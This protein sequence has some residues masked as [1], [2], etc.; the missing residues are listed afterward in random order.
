MGQ[1]TGLCVGHPQDHGAVSVVLVVDYGPVV[2]VVGLDRGGGV[3]R[4]YQIGV[5]GLQQQ[6]VIGAAWRR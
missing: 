5:A 3:N 1:H 2:F 4:G 6:E